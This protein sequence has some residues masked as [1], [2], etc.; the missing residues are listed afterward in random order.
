MVKSAWNCAKQ[1]RVVERIGEI[2]GENGADFLEKCKFWK[3]G[4]WE[5]WKKSS[6]INDSF[7]DAS[8]DMFSI[9]RKCL[10]KESVGNCL[11]KWWFYGRGRK[12]FVDTVIEHVL[13]ELQLFPKM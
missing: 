11:G 6:K 5:R 12:I 1:K 9:S 8:E 7:D 13:L 10:S 3:K 2:K 4:F